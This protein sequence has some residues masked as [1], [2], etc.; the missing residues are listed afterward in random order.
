MIYLSALY[1]MRTMATHIAPGNGSYINT[2]NMAIDYANGNI[3]KLL[4]R[5][6]VKG[7]CTDTRCGGAAWECCEGSPAL[8]HKDVCVGSVDCDSC[9]GWVE[10]N[11]GMFTLLVCTLLRGNCGLL[12]LT[13]NHVVMCMLNRLLH[14][15]LVSEWLVFQTRIA[16]GCALWIFVVTHSGF[17]RELE[18]QYEPF[19]IAFGRGKE[20]ELVTLWIAVY[21]QSNDSSF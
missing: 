5:P 14:F 18:G 4:W 3:S 11:D 1:A 21:E 10:G 17:G 13:C 6:G 9:C 19:C 15:I 7:I 8:Q 12:C 16:D 2:L 20:T